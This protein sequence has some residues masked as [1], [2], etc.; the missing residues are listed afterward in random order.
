M[1]ISPFTMVIRKKK[2]ETNPKPR[3][4]E[5]ECGFVCCGHINLILSIQ[6]HLCSRTGLLCLP[7]E[8]AELAFIKS[9]ILNFFLLHK[10]VCR[11]QEPSSQQ[12]SPGQF[13]ITQANKNTVFRSHILFSIHCNQIIA[14]LWIKFLYTLMFVGGACQQVY[15]PL[16]S[17]KSSYWWYPQNTNW[18]EQ[19]GIK[20]NYWCFFNM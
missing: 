19:A 11:S 5:K 9:P 12:L 16:S 2:K 10:G 6:S 18:Q 1:H 13:I 20:S 3:T 15:I 4:E 14:K 17:Y 7:E 8:E